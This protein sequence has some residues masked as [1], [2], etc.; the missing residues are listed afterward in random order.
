MIYGYEIDDCSGTATELLKTTDATDSTKT[1]DI[2]KYKCLMFK[3]QCTAV[4]N[5]NTWYD[6]Y[7][8]GIKFSK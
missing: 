2:S 7:F 8:N 4:S 6:Y 5:T 3:I 1:Y